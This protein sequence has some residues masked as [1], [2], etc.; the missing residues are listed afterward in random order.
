MSSLHR[1]TVVRTLHLAPEKMLMRIKNIVVMIMILRIDSEC[2]SD[3]GNH[4]EFDDFGVRER[5]TQHFGQSHDEYPCSKS[6]VQEHHCGACKTLGAI[7]RMD[8]AISHTHSLWT[9]L[10]R[11]LETHCFQSFLRAN[12]LDLTR[13]N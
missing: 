1:L 3:V 10:Q 9:A 4:L 11:V 5:E 7:T 12:R 6:N 8:H 2:D 13:R